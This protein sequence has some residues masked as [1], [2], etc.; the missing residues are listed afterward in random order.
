LSYLLLSRLV[1]PKDDG[2]TTPSPVFGKGILDLLDDVLWNLP[3]SSV[4]QAKRVRQDFNIIEDVWNTRRALIR[5]DHRLP[6]AREELERLWKERIDKGLAASP[7]AAG[8]AGAGVVDP[9][10][11]LPLEDE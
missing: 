9:A 6:N 11:A 5:A 7:G 8:A 4:R 10:D 3:F 1:R 2:T